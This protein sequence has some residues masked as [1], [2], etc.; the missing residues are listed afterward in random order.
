MLGKRNPQRSYFDANNLPNQ[1]PDDSFYGRMGV[2]NETLF[3]D[4]D[5]AEMYCDNNGRPSLPPSLMCGVLLLQ[6][7]NDVSDGET[8]ERLKF[9]LR[10]KVALHLPLDYA[11]FDPSS[12]SIFRGRLQ[13]HSKERYAF[14]RFLKVARKSGFIP[15]KVSLLVDTTAVKSAGAVQDTYTLL[16]KGLRK[17]LKTLGYS[18][19][20]KRRGLSTKTETLINTYLLEP[21]HKAEIDWSDQEQR[22][23]QLK[24]LVQDVEQ[25]LDLAAAEANDP[26][27][28][29]LGW[30]LTKILGD[31]LETDENDHPQ[32]AQGTASDRIISITD[33]EMR[34]GR[35][36]SAHRFNGFKASVAIE[37]NSEL[38]MDIHDMAASSGDGKEL[39]P[40]VDRV[41]HHVGVEVEQAIA[42]GAYASG[43]NLAGC[44]NHSPNPVDLLAPL[45]QPADPEVHKSAFHIDQEVQTAT[46]PQGQ[47]VS[48]KIVRDAK[49]REVLKFTFSREI[50]ETCP[51]FSRCV[52]SKTNGRSVTTH[53]HEDHLQAARQRQQTTEFKIRYRKRARVEGK[54]AELAGHGIRNT[55]YLGEPKRQLQRLWTASAVNLKRL[56]TLAD[57][58]KIDLL[59]V[60]SVLGHQKQAAITT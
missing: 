53:F 52:H 4:T 23:S 9:D 10:W 18:V 43:D 47:T 32:I 14:D 56:F 8:V 42:D 59:P 1:V 49:K 7:Y 60:L 19:P 27:V 20:G 46:C 39:I 11:G 54:I 24:T 48:G 58:Q 55:R 37:E 6:Y 13:K 57:C 17:L 22:K 36:S 21:D 5:L 38:I 40:T 12:L 33:P 16:R 41:E 26:E 25:G 50:C 30:L 45:Q 31:D 28:R 51:L 34:H 3:C 29:H 35:K 44:A 15:D 2:V